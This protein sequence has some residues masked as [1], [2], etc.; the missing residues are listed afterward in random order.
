MPVRGIGRLQNYLHRRKLRKVNRS[1]ILTYHRVCNLQNDWQ[2]LAVTPENFELHLKVLLETF[3][4]VSVKDLAE[5]C[6]KGKV[7]DKS[8][9]LTFDDGYFDTHDYVLP[10]L[11]KY[12]VPATVFV[13]SGFID[14]QSEFYWDF[15]EGFYSEGEI[16]SWDVTQKPV[17]QSHSD[18]LNA[19]QKIYS[20]GI[21]Q[22]KSLIKEIVKGRN[23]VR[24]THRVMTKEEVCLCDKSALM[25]I[26]AHTIN[27]PSLK[28]LKLSQQEE[29]IIH[30]SKDLE[31]I[32]GREVKGFAYPYGS[33]NDFT[34]ATKG[35]VESAGFHY[36]LANYP[37]PIWDESDLFALTRY[38]VRN[39]DEDLFRQHL[40]S[41]YNCEG[42]FYQAV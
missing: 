37:G 7:P 19:C 38:V 29:E 17:K 42:L 3:N 33:V 4:V 26:E 35:I 36:A 22:R 5:A 16:D 32:L 2:L 25:D 20:Q 1:M 18:Y 24:S 30:S 12:S 13:S 23:T 15:L 39:W 21:D 8:I 11:E 31:M 14:V 41:W 6:K 9:A 34:Q 10:L 40:L 28:S 27:H